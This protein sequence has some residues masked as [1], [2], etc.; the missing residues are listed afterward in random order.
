M[1][2]TEQNVFTDFKTYDVPN[3]A[4]SGIYLHNDTS[5]VK[6]PNTI[7]LRNDFTIHTSFRPDDIVCDYNKTFDEYCVFSIPGWDTTIAYNSFNRYKFEYWDTEKNP[8]EIT[9]K[10][11]YPRFT[12]MTI[13]H[14][15]TSRLLTVYQDGV[16]IGSHQLRR[17]MLDTKEENFY[18]GVGIPERDNGDIKSFVG[19]IS[20][21][22]YWNNTLGKN[23]VK[24]LNDSMCI[25][26]LNNYEE[27]SSSD[28]LKIYYDFKHIT[29]DRQYQYETSKV[30]NLASQRLETADCFNCIPKTIQD[31]EQKR[32]SIPARRSSTFEMLDH[33]TEGYRQAE[34]TQKTHIE[35]TQSGWKTEST[36]KNQIRFYRNVINNETNLGKDGLSSLKYTALSKTEL[37]NY[38]MLSVKL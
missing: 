21:F 9:S 11:D 10:Y 8:M 5:Y 38:T 36:R 24:E 14:D 2:L 16:E 37:D 23:E 33:E 19:F 30:T 3:L 4:Q 17:R 25:S 15:A 27:Y 12:S 18:L 31:L 13:T 35:Y 32:I 26:L 6:C 22:A 20:E 34:P 28:N 7:D 1:R 29:L